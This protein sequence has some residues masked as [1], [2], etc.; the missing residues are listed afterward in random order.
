MAFKRSW[1]PLFIAA[2][3][4]VMLALAWLPM[5]DLTPEQRSNKPFLYVSYEIQGDVNVQ[6]LEDVAFDVQQRIEQRH[7]WRLVDQP[8]PRAWELT[9]TVNSAQLLV[10]AGNLEA[11]SS[12]ELSQSVQRFKVQGPTDSYAALP[13]Q[14]VK[15]LI[16]LVENGHNAQS[17]L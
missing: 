14:F 9:V 16:Q 1:L 15:I 17:D 6:H 3:V 10:L 12:S 4:V 7:E 2:L 5:G 8:E 13:E 11:P